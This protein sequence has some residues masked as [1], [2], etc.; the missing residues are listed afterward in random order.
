MPSLIVDDLM[1]PSRVN[2][3]LSSTHCPSELGVNQHEHDNSARTHHTHLLQMPEDILGKL[4]EQQ[5]EKVSQQ[6]PSQI[7]PLLPEMISIV[8]IPSLEFREDET[9]DH[10]AE[11]VGF[12]LVTS[13]FRGN[14]WKR[15]LGEDVLGMS[16]TFILGVLTDVTTTS[17]LIECTRLILNRKSLLDRRPDEFGHGIIEDIVA[18]MFHDILVG[19]DSE[20]TEDEDDWDV[21]T[22]VR[23]G[24]SHDVEGLSEVLLRVRLHVHT[25]PTPCTP[26]F[27]SAL[28]KNNL[29]VILLIF[30][31]P[32]LSFTDVTSAT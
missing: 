30:V 17:N 25:A 24:S 32:P 21:L 12:A 19:Q 16:N 22:D 27:F 18:D 1:A 20:T 3:R 29:M 6:R 4:A 9:V 11:E 28:P 8:Q 2:S 14:M 5:T 7:Q 23:E 26:T 10:V 13:F 15:F 31:V